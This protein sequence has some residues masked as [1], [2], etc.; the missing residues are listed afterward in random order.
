MALLQ[1]EAQQEAQDN[2][3]PGPAF[4]WTPRLTKQNLVNNSTSPARG[5]DSDEMEGTALGDQ[6]AVDFAGVFATVQ[7]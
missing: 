6:E 4:G 3:N 2:L 7:L 1:Y 5:V